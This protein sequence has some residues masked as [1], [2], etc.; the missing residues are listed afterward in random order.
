MRRHAKRVIVVSIA[1]AF[2]FIGLIGL[3]LPVI[4][5]LLSIFVGI[6]LL[7][8]YSPTIRKWTEKHTE[9]FPKLHE[10][11]KKIEAWIEK[12]LGTP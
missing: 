3:V 12:I 4:Q 5:G 2:L 9:R 1:F 7:S 8:L 6:I 11:V 10:F